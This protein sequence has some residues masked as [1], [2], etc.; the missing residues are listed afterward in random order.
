MS[1]FGKTLARVMVKRRT[2]KAELARRLGVKRQTVQ[3]MCDVGNPGRERL[4]ELV[5]ILCLD[6]D[7]LMSI[8]MSGVGGE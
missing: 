3:S 4:K 5:D 2:T 1:T 6:D 7:E 8:V